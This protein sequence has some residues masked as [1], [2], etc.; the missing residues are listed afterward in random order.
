MASKNPD[1]ATLVMRDTICNHTTI[2]ELVIFLLDNWTCKGHLWKLFQKT[3]TQG[4]DDD[5]SLVERHLALL[6]FRSHTEPQT[7]TGWAK[8][9]VAATKDAP[10]RETMRKLDLSLETF[11]EHSVMMLSIFNC[12][13][14]EVKVTE[15]LMAFRYPSVPHRTKHTYLM[16]YDHVPFHVKLRNHLI[17]VITVS[18]SLTELA[19]T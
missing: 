14:S 4:R 17:S 6:P 18:T 3:I 16:Y 2:P 5:G 7:S 9:G 1:C 13:Q 8:L 12:M 15:L 11:I 10:C 19:E